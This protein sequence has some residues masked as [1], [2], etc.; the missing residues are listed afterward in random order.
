MNTVVRQLCCQG[1]GAALPV[2]EGIRFLTCNYCHAHLEIVQ[3]QATTHTRLLEGIEQRT[4]KIERDVETIR[5]Q[6]DLKQLDE[7]WSNYQ[8]RYD[9]RDERGSR[10][11][12]TGGLI[13]LGLVGVIVGIVLLR[14]DAWWLGMVLAPASAWFMVMAFRWEKERSRILQGARLQY[15]MRRKMLLQRRSGGR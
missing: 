10:D 5:I 2:T 15:E 8:A 1:C 14:S 11:E 7:A 4:K 9:P 6:N 3:D 12:P 13:G